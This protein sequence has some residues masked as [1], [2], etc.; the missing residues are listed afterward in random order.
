MID[1]GLK[2][3]ILK[4]SGRVINPSIELLHHTPLKI[5]D[6]AIGTCWDKQRGGDVTDCLRMNKVANKFKHAST[7]EHL[8]YNCYIK[9]VSR[10]LLQELMRTRIASPSVKSSR[11]TLKELKSVKPFLTDLEYIDGDFYPRIS[12]EQFKRAGKYLIFTGDLGIDRGSIIELEVLR[13]NVAKNISNDYTKYN[14][15]ESYKTELTFSINA[16]SLQNLLDLRTNKAALLE[17]RRLAFTLYEKIPDD[18]KFLFDGLEVDTIKNELIEIVNKKDFNIKFDKIESKTTNKD[19][20]DMISLIK[21]SYILTG[22]IPEIKYEKNE[23]YIVDKIIKLYKR[24]PVESTSD[25]PG[26]WLKTKP[27][28]LA[29]D[30]VVSDY[31]NYRVS[32]GKKV[33]DNYKL[34]LTQIIAEEDFRLNVFKLGSKDIPLESRNI[35]SII[36]STI[37]KDDIV[38]KIVEK[39]TEHD[40]KGFIHVYRTITNTNGKEGTS[41]KS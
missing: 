33:L 3:E 13:S 38:E 35:A 30:V 39:F 15:P 9:D 7:I 37:I 6:I 8:Y 36:L 4:T 24:I 23:L 5:A 40:I 14:L 27:E 21:S 34:E 19:I 20:L 12:E 17:I 10:G 2:D 41:N 25:K 11:Y 22:G 1:I 16:R 29:D 31:L 26:M 32:G 18:H 28:L